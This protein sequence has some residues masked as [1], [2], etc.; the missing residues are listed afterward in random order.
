MGDERGRI[1]WA[2]TA[3][4]AFLLGVL[5]IVVLYAVK[6]GWQR[7]ERTSW[8]RPLDVA[9]VV[10]EREPVDPESI[11]ALGERAAALESRL[12]EE[13][14]RYGSGPPPFRFQLYGP[15]PV[16]AKPPVPASDG[17]VDLAVHAF[18]SWRYFRD[19]N[20][21]A[22]IPSRAFDSLVYLIV[23]P[24]AGSEH[25]AVEGQSEQGGRIGSV[26]VEIDPTMVDFTLFVATHELLHTLGASDKYDARGFAAVPAGL[27]EPDRDPLYPQVAAEVMARNVVLGQGSERP[28][29]SL[30]ELR[31]GETTAR[32]IGWLAS[33]P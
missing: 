28:P 9:L 13:R 30:D 4:I 22:N 7:R 32:E 2:R 18:H 15:V 31:V 29:D 10:V 17:L 12:G 6:D 27:A 8:K 1:N 16:G 20:E 33:P 24:A 11:G 26:E 3:R 23:R 5:A 21:R 19:V 14:S 25:N